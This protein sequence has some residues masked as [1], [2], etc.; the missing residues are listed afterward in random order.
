MVARLQVV[1]AHFNVDQL[2]GKHRLM[3]ICSLSIILYYAL[4]EKFY[5]FISVFLNWFSIQSVVGSVPT[6]RR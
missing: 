5:G 3:N 2:L 6:T 4:I 1:A